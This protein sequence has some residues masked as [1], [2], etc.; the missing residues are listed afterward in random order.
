LTLILKPGPPVINVDDDLVVVSGN[1]ESRNSRHDI[2]I[3]TDDDDDDDCDDD[4]DEAE[5]FG[6][7]VD[8]CFLRKQ[9]EDLDDSGEEIVHSPV[10]WKPTRKRSAAAAAAVI[11]ATA[12]R[13]SIDIASDD[14]STTWNVKQDIIQK[15]KSS[16]LKCDNDNQESDD[17]KDIDIH[18]RL[19]KK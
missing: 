5:T 6:D 13:I 12:P 15:I 2:Q 18:H 16:N 14:E 10:T 19:R 3:N 4:I 9:D 7:V 17:H 1:K 8:L 11:A